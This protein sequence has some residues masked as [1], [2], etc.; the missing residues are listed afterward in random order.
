[1][2][3]VVVVVVFVLP[4]FRP[5]CFCSL[6]LFSRRCPD[7]VRLFLFCVCLSRVSCCSIIS[8]TYVVRSFCLSFVR[9]FVRLRA[10]PHVLRVDVRC[11]SLFLCPTMCFQSFFESFGC[12]FL[13]L[14]VRPFCMSFWSVSLV[15]ISCVLA[16]SC[17]IFFMSCP[18]RLLFL[19]FICVRGFVFVIVVVRSCVLSVVLS[20]LLP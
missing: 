2:L 12:S 10:C 8:F 1:M 6:L 9:S 13:Q 20:A 14:L 16:F 3:F 15:I 19:I 18:R 11:L 7:F 17:R 5:L 4:F